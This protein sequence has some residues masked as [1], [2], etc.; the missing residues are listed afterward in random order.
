[1]ALGAAVLG[2]G[3]GGDPHLAKLMLRR[4]IDRYGPVP[5]IEA[6]DVPD[7]GLV[8]P[9]AV[10]GAPTVLVEKF[11]G[12]GDARRAL[13][14]MQRFAG[15]TGVAVLPLEI[16]AI[17]TLFPLV[18]AAEVGLPCVDAD[19]MRRALPQ[20]ETTLFTLAGIDVSPVCVVG[21]LGNALVIDAN[22]NRTGE[23]LTRAAVAELG[24]V[25]TVAAYPMSGEQC[26]EHAAL[27][28][29]SHCLEVGRRLRAIHAGRP[30]AHADF[31]AFTGAEVVF[32]GTVT[33]VLR[34]TSGGW[35]R[36]TATLEH[37]AAPDRLLRVDFQ[38][39]NLVVTENG[40]AVAT[41]PDVITLLDVDTGWPVT[42]ES[43]TYGQRVE[44]L[45]MPAH[46]RWLRP[47]GLALAGPRA[48]GYDL[49]YV[50]RRLPA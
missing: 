44:V 38:N 1:M 13:E 12:E 16:G 34:R 8:L 41:V 37:L 50:E 32:N 48:F 7:G 31:L 4:A 39:E 15:R 23:R 33:D 5:V 26:R 20:L 45:V 30:D 21:A 9:V 47:D 25:A 46:E 6:A 10:V 28:S 35:T 14:A 17:N 49:D 29:L 43:V 11:P 27:G 19:G 24:M 18:A 22:D 2:C 3:G 40:R 36:G 42:T